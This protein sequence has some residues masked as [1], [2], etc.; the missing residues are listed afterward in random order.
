MLKSRKTLSLSRRASP[1]LYDVE[2]SF[3]PP[4]FI[5]RND[6][7][8]AN[9]MF[10]CVL[11]IPTLRGVCINSFRAHSNTCTTC[12][13]EGKLANKHT[14]VTKNNNEILSLVDDV[15]EVDAL[16]LRSSTSI[17]S[18]HTVDVQLLLI[19]HHC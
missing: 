9:S 13:L 19:W 7:C 3:L 11:N 6:C 1:G 5:Q 10:Q 18:T 14:Y 2:R 4:G 17:P 15:Q 12:M 8:Y 16:S